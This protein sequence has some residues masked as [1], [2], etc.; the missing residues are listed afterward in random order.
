MYRAYRAYRAHT[1][2]RT[3]C[4]WLSLSLLF[5]LQCTEDVSEE[6]SA[7]WRKLADSGDVEQQSTTTAVC[8]TTD[9][10]RRGR[11]LYDYTFYFLVTYVVI[12]F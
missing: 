11:R 2:P 10:Q 6:I 9:P 3:Q 8:N 1:F 5:E 12:N 7:I 4:S